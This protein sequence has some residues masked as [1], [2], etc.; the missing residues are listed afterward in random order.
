MAGRHTQLPCGL[1]L[2]PLASQTNKT[3]CFASPAFCKVTR[4]HGVALAP[5]PF[6]AWHGLES[7]L[8]SKQK[9]GL[10]GT[11][12]VGPGSLSALYIPV[13]GLASAL[14]SF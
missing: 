3:R 1:R 6:S 14:A 10:V 12:A 4:A 13:P 11:L 7:E 9:T 2:A 5:Q 8:G